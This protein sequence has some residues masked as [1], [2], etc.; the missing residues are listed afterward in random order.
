MLG[1]VLRIDDSAYHDGGMVAWFTLFHADDPRVDRTAPETEAEAEAEPGRVLASWSG[2]DDR[3]GPLW[4]RYRVDGGSWSRWTR[5]GQAELP[6]AAPGEHVLEVVARDGWFNEDLSP[7]LAR[8][9]VTA[10]EVV[11]EEPAGC[12]CSSPG[13]GVGCRSPGCSCSSG[14]VVA[15]RDA[16]AAEL[17]G[18]A[19]VVDAVVAVVD[20]ARSVS[21]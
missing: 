13:G 11:E 3:E 7:A 16:A 9:S 19:G 2:E 20:Q 15:G 1:Y 14:S 18:G 17:S 8:F 6:E 5:R 10:P 12:G 21:A 4:F